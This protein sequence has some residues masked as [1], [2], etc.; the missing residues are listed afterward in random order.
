[1]QDH[2]DNLAAAMMFSPRNFSVHPLTIN[3][4]LAMTSGGSF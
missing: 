4:I 1:M 3:D 2:Q